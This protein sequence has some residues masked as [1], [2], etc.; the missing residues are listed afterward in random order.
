M[1]VRE[2][3]VLNPADLKYLLIESLL[4]YSS[5][6]IYIGG[7][8]PYRF[9]LN[10]K[11]FFVLIKNVHESGANRENQDE[12]RIQISRSANFNVALSSASDVVVLG[13]YADKRVFTAWNPYML[14]PRFNARSTVSV[15]SRFSVQEE[16]GN[17]GISLYIDTR[18][19]RVISFKP[20]YLGLYLEN[21]ES[22]HSLDQ[23]DLM[24][25]VRRSDSPDTAGTPELVELG[26]ERLT[27]THTQYAR[28]PRFRKSVY[29][30]YDYRCA[31]CGIQ[32]QLVEAAHIVP[33]SHEKGTDEVNNGVCL[34]ALHHTAYDQS[35][36]YFDE[37]F[38]I[39]LNDSKL[40]YLV[41]IKRDSGL[42]TLLKMHFSH[43]SLPRN[44]IHHPYIEN[45]GIANS[46]RG[47][48]S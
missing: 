45:I 38:Q 16:A 40:A 2:T 32:L 11:E 24:S 21:L 9:S 19:Q 36:I 43:I 31:M 22:I 47:I 6:V 42:S 37:T 46:I 41:K 18:G 26:G 25:L 10:K 7:H 15:Y 1:S 29:D 33:H 27:I 3:L 28:D 12:C 13:Y 20:E 17:S 30:A 35:L 48:E 39:K 44:Q 4:T 5:D 8:N 34:C 23:E 14:R